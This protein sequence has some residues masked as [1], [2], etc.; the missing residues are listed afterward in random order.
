MDIT[1]MST[2]L[3]ALIISSILYSSWNAMYRRRDL[4]PGPTPLP[5]VGNV[6]Q[7]RRGK[8]VQSLMEFAGKYG[9]VYTVYFGHNPI[10]VLSG[11][12]TVKEALLD[13]AEEFGGRGKSTFDY[14]FEGHGIVFS[15]GERWK[16]LRRFSLTMLRNFGMGKKSIEEKIQEEAGFLVAEIKSL[17][18]KSIDPSNLLSQAVSNVICSIVFG[19]RFEY[20]DQNF[21]QLLTLFSET[22]KDASGPLGQLQ[23]MLPE[24]MYYIPGPHQRIKRH[25]DKLVNFVLERVKINQET[26]DP[27]CPRD[28]I[29]CF[30]VKQQQEKGNPHFDTRDMILSILNLFFGG[31]ETVSSTL[32][33]A[34]LILM[35]YPEIQDKVLEEINQIIGQNRIPQIEDRNKMPYTDAVIHEIQRFSDIFPADLPHLVTK[36]INFKG[37]T[38]PKGTDVYPLLCTV[39][40]DP[41]MFTTPTKFNPNH[42]LDSNGCFKKNEAYMPFS[43]GKRICV[44]E[45]LARMELFL[46]ITTI[47]QNF[48][49][50]SKIKITDEDIKPTMTGSANIPI[51]YEMS[52]IS[53]AL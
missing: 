21:R 2:V 8:L 34:F 49:L 31:T 4:P 29:D 15:N 33:N 36:E 3:L 10:V 51:F 12:E 44:G 45:A 22:F 23:E 39:H 53:R 52:F 41:K 26:L 47:L 46:F 37:Y 14:F 27:N 38:I 13:R 24:I 16:D 25:L 40:R 7:I 42:F 35:K 9:S 28:Y 19:N 18:E 50:T 5:I 11:Y 43:A 48:K 20:D 1:W 32:R 17:K 30:L 6:L